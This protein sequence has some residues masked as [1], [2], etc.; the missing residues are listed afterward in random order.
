MNIHI[1]ENGN[2]RL[3]FDSED[4]KEGIRHLPSAYDDVGL[5]QVLLEPYTVNGSFTPFD[6]GLANPPVGLT[7]APCIAESMEVT[8]DGNIVSKGQ[9]VWWFPNY[10]IRGP[11]DELLRN[12]CVDFDF[13][14][15]SESP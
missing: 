13:G 6:A 14:F 7:N 5:L 10:Q 8:E 1:L 9:R 11:I 12:G 4:E 2:L 15:V 3:C